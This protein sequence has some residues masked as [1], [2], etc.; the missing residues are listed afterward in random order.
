MFQ[1]VSGLASREDHESVFHNCSIFDMEIFNVHVFL[2]DKLP[3]GVSGAQALVGRTLNFKFIIFK[4][5]IS[6]NRNGLSFV[7]HDIDLLCHSV[8]TWQ[9][10]SF[11]PFITF[12]FQLITLFDFI[13]AQEED[14]V[15]PAKFFLERNS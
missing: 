13:T 3:I 8:E 4:V 5:N 12:E 1:N 15:D 11:Y 2:A 10:S 7:P 9:F 14:A 6:S